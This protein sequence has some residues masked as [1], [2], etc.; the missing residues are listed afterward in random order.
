[1]EGLSI[2]IPVYNK[3]ETTLKCINSIFELNKSCAFEVIIVD[4]GSTDDTEK[5]LTANDK[6]IYIRNRENLGMAGGCNTGAGEA[7]YNIL[8]FMHNDVF[9]SRK[10]W[11]AVI[12]EF[13][14]ETS[15]A[16]VVGLYG[17]KTIRKDGSFR[18]KSIV[19]AKKGN[20]SI[21]RISE[22]TAVVDGLLMAI[23]KS[24][25]KEIRGF[26]DDFTIHFYDKDLSMRAVKH[27][28]VNYVL[29]IPFEHYCAT[30]RENIKTE[31]RVRVEAQKK[32][33]E[34]WHKQL[35]VDVTTWQE[36]ISYIFKGKK[37]N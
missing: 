12:N 23:R 24:A 28:Y 21:T 16:G 26:S 34:I 2:I 3:I 29:N 13:I 9:V 17:A 4:N 6:I 33:I 5:V 8:C 27:G 25:F 11:T 35:P 22:K 37:D 32:F 36:K 1:M 7:G 30:T 14:N 31:D 18:G 15:N 19:H 20:P 10:N